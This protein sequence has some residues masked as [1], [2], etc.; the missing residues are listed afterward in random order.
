M[1][2]QEYRASTKKLRLGKE[3]NCPKMQLMWC[4]E[5]EPVEIDDSFWRISSVDKA[6][7]DSLNPETK[8]TEFALRSDR[9]PLL[10]V[11]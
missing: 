9:T 2:A 7:K 5:G 1:W 10:P 3:L 6:A 4:Y 8:P 11:P